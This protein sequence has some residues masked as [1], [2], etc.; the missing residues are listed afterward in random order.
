MGFL[1]SKKEPAKRARTATAIKLVSVETALTEANLEDNDAWLRHLSQ[2][3]RPLKRAGLSVKEEYEQ[4]LVARVS[5]R[6][7]TAPPSDSQA[8]SSPLDSPE[9]QSKP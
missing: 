4:W 5:V 9:S 1:F 3:N 6:Q 8:N 2:P 7:A